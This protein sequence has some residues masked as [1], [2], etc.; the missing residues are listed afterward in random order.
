MPILSDR[1][2]VFDLLDTLIAMG[3]GDRNRDKIP[4]AVIAIAL[5]NPRKPRG[6]D[7]REAKA[8]KSGSGRRVDGQRMHPP[9]PECGS[10]D[11][12]WLTSYRD[13][14]LTYLRCRACRCRYSV[15]MTERKECA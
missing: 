12:E 11:Y 13:K 7:Y 6:N 2:P 5:A 3:K 8:A 9:C 4:P 14:A 15:P 1:D 10:P